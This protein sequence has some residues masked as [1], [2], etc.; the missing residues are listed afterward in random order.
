MPFGQIVFGPPGS[1]KT[2]YC[3]AMQQFLSAL[4]RKV[5]VINLDPANDNLPYKC[6]IDI[7]TLIK[8]EEVMEQTELG[9]NG[10][11]IY[12]MEYLEKNLDWL[13]QELE[14][15]YSGSEIAFM[16]LF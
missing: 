9:P 8:M 14:K 15:L 4:Q 2:T 12:S 7:S 5:A 6:S 3:D 10:A 11:F 1:G 13:H 16:L